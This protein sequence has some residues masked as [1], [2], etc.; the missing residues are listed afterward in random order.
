MSKAATSEKRS[1]RTTRSGFASVRDLGAIRPVAGEE[2][3]EEGLGFGALGSLV[4]TPARREGGE[5]RPDLLA[6]EHGG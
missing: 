4:N 2:L 1:H 3:V 5:S 6:G